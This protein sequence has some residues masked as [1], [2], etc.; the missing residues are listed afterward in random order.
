M[1]G[2]G[3]AMTLEDLYRLLRSGHVQAQGVVDTM[4]QPVVVLDRNLCVTTANNA[5]ISTFN[6]DRDDTLGQN[7][8]DLGNGQWDVPE[9]RQLIGSVIPKAAAVI[10]YEV[11]HDFPGVGQR[12]FLVDARRLVHPDDNNRNILVIFDDVTERQ[13][14]DAESQFVLSETRHRMA[15]LVAV[16]RALAYQTSVDGVSASHYRDALIGRLEATVRAQ[17]FAPNERP[18]D[19]KSV[20]RA[21][22]GEGGKD[23]LKLDGPDVVVP[24]ESLLAI[25]M[26]FH[27]LGTNALKYGALSVPGGSVS[28]KWAVQDDARGRAILTC[29]WREVDGPAVSP[30]SRRGY[31]THLMEGMSAHVGGRVELRYEQ[32]G[33]SAV[34]IIPM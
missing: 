13:R 15:N 4:T 3:H 21:S 30:P 14:L 22:V 7:F 20:I 31:G 23:R 34:I 16:V 19:L 25:G 12:T 11:K 2:G 29:E 10:G 18:A 5:F 27:E 8:F 6:V 17:D 26:I 28:V 32:T 24:P 9:L 1:F 33:L